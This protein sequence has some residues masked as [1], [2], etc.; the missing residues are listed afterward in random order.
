[1]KKMIIAIS[2]LMGT[3]GFVQ[4]QTTDTA[5]SSANQNMMKES[6]TKSKAGLREML[7]KA[8]LTPDQKRKV[9]E[10]KKASKEKEDAI[11]NNKSLSDTDRQA[12]LKELRK[13]TKKNILSVLTPEQKK[14][15]ME[16]K[17]SNTDKS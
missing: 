7:E 8:N 13:Q 12:Q 11:N 4:A 5:S 16:E 3:V 15:M 14:Q 6:T 10:Y 2:F 1:M 9:M 17:Q